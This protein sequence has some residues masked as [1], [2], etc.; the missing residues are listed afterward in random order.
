MGIDPSRMIKL[1]QRRSSAGYA[2]HL[3]ECE[4]SGKSAASSNNSEKPLFPIRL[5]LIG[6]R[7]YSSDLPQSASLASNVEGICSRMEVRPDSWVY[8]QKVFRFLIGWELGLGLAPCGKE[9]RL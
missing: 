8:W 6:S 4:L 9:H 1:L 5:S 7:F 2:L 3:I